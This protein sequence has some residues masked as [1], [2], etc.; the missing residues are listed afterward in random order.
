MCCR[1]GLLRQSITGNFLVSHNA[2]IAV[3]GDAELVVCFGYRD[4]GTIHAERL[5]PSVDRLRACARDD[6]KIMEG[7]R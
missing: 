3:N 5:I 1:R 7:G 4:A 6:H 2:N